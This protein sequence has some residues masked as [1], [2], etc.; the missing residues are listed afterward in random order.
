MRELAT[1]DRI[2]RLIEALGQRARGPGRIY[3]VGGATAVLEGWR[4][5]TKDVDVALDPEPAGVFEAIRDLKDELALNIELASPDHFIP[6]VP[7]WR[8]RSL[9]IARAGPLEFFHYDPVSQALAKIERGHAQDLL[10][11]EQLFGRRLVSAQQLRDGFD[12]IRAA[13]IRY[14]GLDADSFATKVD[15]ALRQLVAAPEPNDG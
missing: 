9:F 11:V 10:D 7:G 6:A 12:S 1:A 8:E 5:T 14:P 3:L 15:E 13:L 4:E 2:R